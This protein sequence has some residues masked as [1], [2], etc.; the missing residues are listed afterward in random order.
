GG[1]LRDDLRLAVVPIF[2]VPG[3]NWGLGCPHVHLICPVRVILPAT[4]FSTFA[5]QLINPDEGR[6]Y[7]DEEWKRW[8]EAA[9]YECACRG[10]SSLERQRA[11]VSDLPSDVS[12]RLASR[13]FRVPTVRL[14]RGDLWPVLV[15]GGPA[16][17]ALVLVALERAGAVHGATIVPHNHI[18]RLPFVRVDEPVLGREFIQFVEQRKGFFIGH[19]LDTHSMP[20]HVERL[21]AVGRCSD[22]GMGHARIVPTHFLILELY[23][24]ALQRTEKIVIDLKILDAVLHFRR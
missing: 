15:D 10:Q 1:K 21:A 16:E 7:I 4:G 18:A 13:R 24:V 2:H 6:P 8:R 12:A 23:A 9:G 3:K 20:S 5:L 11:E 14:N 17:I 19:P 22:Q